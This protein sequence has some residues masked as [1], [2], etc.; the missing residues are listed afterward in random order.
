MLKSSEVVPIHSL[1][2][3]LIDPA[4]HSEL[5]RKRDHIVDVFAVVVTGS[6]DLLP[7]HRTLGDA[8]SGLGTLVLAGYEGFHETCVAE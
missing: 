1:S 3:P 7:A 2:L 5:H 8:L 4:L 6:D